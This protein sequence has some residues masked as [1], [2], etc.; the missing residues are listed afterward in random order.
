MDFTLGP[1][2]SETRKRAGVS[3]EELAARARVPASELASLEEGKPAELSTAAVARMARV[4]DV[5]VADWAGDPDQASEPSLFFRQT[6]IPDFFDSDRVSVVEALREARSVAILDGLLRREYLRR[7]FQPIEVG[8]VPWEQGYELA[9][10]VR[11]ALGAPTEP[12]GSIGEI[13]EDSFGVPVLKSRL[14]ADRVVALT[15]KERGSSYAAVVVNA[16]VT[17]NVR[18]HLAHELA[19]VLFDAPRQEI[20]LWIDLDDEADE[21]SR[22]EKRAK[23]F[24]VELLIPRRGLI[25]AFGL[26]HERAGAGSSLE[27]SK[28]LA[29]RVG[30]HFRAP[31]ELTTNHLVNNL[32]IAE[33]L[34]EAVWRSIR[35]AT[36]ASPPRQKMIHRRLEEALRAGL[37]TEMRARELLGLSVRDPIPFPQPVEA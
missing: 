25:D 9:R 5:D 30:E 36:P 33:D 23:A 18:V 17:E 3:L 7:E 29:R 11:Q 15:A 12:L 35:I 4:L 14:A 21:T 24:A 34:R 2:I 31:P 28:L 10:R 27:E 22:I 8:P 19:H 6:G 16:K 37:V 13:I 26:P 20:D 1:R 32:Y